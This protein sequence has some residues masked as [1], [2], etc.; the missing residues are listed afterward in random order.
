MAEMTV[1]RDVITRDERLGHNTDVIADPSVTRQ[2]AVA[3]E[4]AMEEVVIGTGS[5]SLGMIIS[6]LS[7]S[8]ETSAT[9]VVSVA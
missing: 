3:I 1:S 8:V 2:D 9:E 6:S 5:S 4:Y 7:D